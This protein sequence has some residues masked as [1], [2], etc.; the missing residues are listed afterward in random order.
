[1]PTIKDYQSNRHHKFDVLANSFLQEQ[2][3][4]FSQVLNAD[5]INQVFQ[6]EDELFGQNDIFSTEIR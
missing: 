6:D 4:P 2:G 5:F 1:M 3:L